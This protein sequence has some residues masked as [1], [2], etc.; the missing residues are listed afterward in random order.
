MDDISLGMIL[1][2]LREQKGLT[3]EDIARRIHIRKTVV[4][5]IE[6][7]QQIDVPLVF[8]KGYIRAYAE[9]V[10]L[11]VDGY[12]PYIDFL[13]LQYRS[14][15]EKNYTQNYKKKKRGLGIL[16]FSLFIIVGV[17]SITIYCVNYKN[18][19]N[20]VE[21][22]HYISPSSNQINS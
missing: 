7:D 20:F 17:F 4:A 11:S 22:S 3:Q 18:K 12:Q 19:S 2:S 13:A 10:G 8:I 14:Y 15:Q 6:K 9:L 1:A 16:F 21:V 5:D